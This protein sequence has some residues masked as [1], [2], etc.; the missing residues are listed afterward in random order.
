MPRK[1]FATPVDVD[2]LRAAHALAEELGR[3][4]H[5]LVEEALRDLL[6]KHRPTGPRPHA[7]AAYRDSHKKFGRLYKKLAE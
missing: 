6:A 4:F 7:M 3:P 2:V 1:K 5:A